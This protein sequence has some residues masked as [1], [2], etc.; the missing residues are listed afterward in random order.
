MISSHFQRTANQL[1]SENLPA[2]GRQQVSEDALGF[3]AGTQ[4]I[5]VGGPALTVSS[6]RI[7]AVP[8]GLVI[9]PSTWLDEIPDR[10]DG[11]LQ[12]SSSS[13]LPVRGF[14]Q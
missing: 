3:V 9:G 2:V 14:G 7:F 11:V 12:T 8:G 10:S 5:V 1:L 6:E 4:Q 13:N